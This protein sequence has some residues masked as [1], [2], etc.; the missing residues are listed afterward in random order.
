MR[1]DIEFALKAD[2]SWFLGHATSLSS[3]SNEREFVGLQRE[4]A[5]EQGED[6]AELE[7]LGSEAETLEEELWTEQPSSPISSSVS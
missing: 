6:V 5:L 7:L 2:K 4:N 3:G 1:A